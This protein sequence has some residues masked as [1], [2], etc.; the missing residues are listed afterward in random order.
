MKTHSHTQTYKHTHTHTHT[1]T[2]VNTDIKVHIVSTNDEFKRGVKQYNNQFNDLCFNHMKSNNNECHIKNKDCPF[3][4]AAQLSCNSF[5]KN[6]LFL[7][8]FYFIFFSFLFFGVF[9]E[10]ICKLL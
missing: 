1:H 3:A 2:H 6:I 10:S 7:F 8:L 9:C 4:I 5:D